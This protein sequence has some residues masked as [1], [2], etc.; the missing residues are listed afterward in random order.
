MQL[1]AI[2]TVTMSDLVCETLGQINDLD[3]VEGAA[4]DTHTAT[5]AKV[6]GDEAD[7]RAGFDINTNLASLVERAGLSAL[8]FTLFGFAL[9]R[10]DNGDSKF[11]V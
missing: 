5:N 8:L 7:S 3:C 1:E 6:L 2:S 10:V 9:I 11:L 4:L